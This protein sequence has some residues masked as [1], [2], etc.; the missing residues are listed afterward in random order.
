LLLG[1]PMVL[2]PLGDKFNVALFLFGCGLGWMVSGGLTLRGYLQNTQP[3]VGE[4]E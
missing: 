3:P 4:F 2:L 1:A